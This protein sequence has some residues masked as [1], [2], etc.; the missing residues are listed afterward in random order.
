MI[1][2][3]LYENDANLKTDITN[4]VNKDDLR[5][6][7]YDKNICINANIY[8]IG[9]TL[10]IYNLK[11]ILMKNERINSPIKNIEINTELPKGIYVVRLTTPNY[12]I[13][14]LVSID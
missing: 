13:S 10:N 7:S 4:Y 14:K 8:L 1:G 6:Y 2:Y 9:A 5:L 11:D 3:S 12:S